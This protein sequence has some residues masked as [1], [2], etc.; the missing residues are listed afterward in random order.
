VPGPPLELHP[1][2]VAL[3]HVQ[4]HLHRQVIVLQLVLPD[5]E[6]LHVGRHDEG[7]EVLAIQLHEE[8]RQSLPGTVSHV[9]RTPGVSP[10]LSE[11]LVG[12]CEPFIGVPKLHPNGNVT[13]LPYVPFREGFQEEPVPHMQLKWQEWAIHALHKLNIIMPLTSSRSSCHS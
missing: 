3:T 10:R 5:Q 1:M 2:F 6:L 9:S 7:T 11:L 4:G 8:C 12:L 13:C